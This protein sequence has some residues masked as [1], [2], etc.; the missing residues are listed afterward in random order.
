MPKVQKAPEDLVKLAKKTVF[1]Y[2]EAHK[3][4]DLHLPRAEPMP[5]F[6]FDAEQIK[7]CLINLLDN[8]VA[9]LPDG[10]RIDIEISPR[11][12]KRKMSFSRCT[13]MARGSPKRIN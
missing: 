6:S 8:A 9:V 4:I 3:H 10:G 5:I 7:R 12:R 1:L 2:Q 11:H 13:T